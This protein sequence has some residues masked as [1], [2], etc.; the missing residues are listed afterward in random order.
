[1]IYN[2]NC[3]FEKLFDYIFERYLVII[4]IF[5]LFSKYYYKLPL[6]HWDQIYKFGLSDY[7]VTHVDEL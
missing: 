5:T 2:Y 3:S 6:Y 7:Y 4:I 1:M